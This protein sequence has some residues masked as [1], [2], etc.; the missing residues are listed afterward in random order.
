MIIFS[1]SKQHI[2]NSKKE[3][4][5]ELFF[6]S[7]IVLVGL[8]FFHFSKLQ[9]ILFFILYF[10]DAGHVYSSFLELFFDK[11]LF[12]T[13]RIILISLA[14]ILVNFIA[15]YLFFG[16]FFVFFFYLTIFHYINQGMVFSLL[17]ES[18]SQ[19]LKFKSKIIYLVLTIMPVIIFHFKGVHLGSDVTYTLRPINLSAYLSSETMQFIYS[20]FRLFYFFLFIL[21]IL[22]LILKK[23]ESCFSIIFYSAVYLLSFLIFD[24][25]VWGMLLL[26][27]THGVPYFFIYNKRLKL[28]HSS[29]LVKK[30]STLFL[31]LLFILGTI[32]E[33]TQEDASIN[34]PPHIRN[35]IFSIV[36]YPATVHYFFEYFNWKAGNERFEVFKKSILK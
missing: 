23:A 16:N 35:Y 27:T 6:P 31:I 5:F 9:P 36:F 30:H 26:A 29:S 15:T 33:L 20:N 4:F 14:A 10:I 1:N 32:F 17:Y 11:K 25:V 13:K 22:Y 34:F 21:S 12:R 2:L 18:K 7:I 28:T 8:N 19:H 3:D 24:N